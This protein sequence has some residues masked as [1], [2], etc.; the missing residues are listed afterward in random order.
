VTM[1]D[2]P[3]GSM[4][5]LLPL[6]VSG[7]LAAADH[8]TV[9]AHVRGCVDCTAEVALLRVVSQAYPAHAVDVSAIVA[10]LPVPARARTRIPFHRQPIWR[11]AATFTLFIV[12]TATV[13]VVRGPTAQAPGTA[14]GTSVPAAPE[15]TLA[16]ATSRASALLSLGTDF[17][18]L[19]DSQLES[20][21]GSLDGLDPRPQA[22]P[23]T[24]ATPIIQEPTKAPGRSNQ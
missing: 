17:S 5:D 9:E 15:T 3:D 8:A 14:V 24:I 16:G 19:S 11:V 22:D 21:L 4:R 20:L 13:M 10:R 2:C 6:H 12:G 1:R 23:M 18:D 7:R